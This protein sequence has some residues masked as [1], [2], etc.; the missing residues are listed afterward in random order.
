MTEVADP[1]ERAA[2]AAKAMLSRQFPGKPISLSPASGGLSNHVFHAEVGSD[3]LVVRLARADAKAQIM[4]REREAGVP[5][6]DVVAL[7]EQDGFVVMVARRIPGEIAKDHPH[8]AR[9]LH[10]LGTLAA[11]RIHTIATRGYGCD[12]TFDGEERGGWKGW[13]DNELDV[14]GRLA[15]LREHALIS[16]EREADLRERI[17]SIARWSGEPILNHGDLRLKNV[18][19]D[20]D[21]SILGLIDRETAVSL[22]TPQWDLS[23][24]LH[25]LGVDEAQAFLSGYGMDAEAARQAAPVWRLFNCLNYAPEVERA[26]AGEDARVLNDLRLR[27]S[28]SLDLFSRD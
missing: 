5:A 24:A 19:V 4:A 10:D 21:G 17:A 9:T 2:D 27:F 20:G 8:R 12:F 16:S 3:A 13:L 22:L 26:V 25:D 6:P 1:K 7:D 11:E 14:D 18:L 15:L 28:G 23:I